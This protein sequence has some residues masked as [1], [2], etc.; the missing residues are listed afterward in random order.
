MILSIRRGTDP[1][2]DVRRCSITGAKHEHA[3]YIRTSLSSDMAKDTLTFELGGR[4]EITDFAAGIAAFS[5]LVNALTPRNSGIAWIVEDLQPGSAVVTFRG[6]SAD[7]AAVEH[8][9]DQYER[10][11]D[12]LERRE[13][14]PQINSRVI[15][16]I[17]AI[18]DL[19]ETTEYVRFQTSERDC[20]I[21][22]SGHTSLR[23]PPT[24]AI[25]AVTGRV[26]TL[27]NRGGLRF[28]LYDTLHDKAVACYLAPDQDEIM[29]EAWGSRATV[30][31]RVS[32][33]A[34]NGR[35]IAIRQ[36]IAV[37][38]LAET[39]RGSYQRARGTVAWQVGDR[40]P[41]EVIRDLRD[42]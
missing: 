35:P 38:S 37:E 24:V 13:D 28:N 33:D 12:T 39:E 32:R 27:S 1:N 42:A 11:G 8:I 26:Q 9:V 15:R 40:L 20:T 4:V 2:R 29:R 23:R 10:I 34:L 6:E 36:I 7:P 18:R 22:R 3:T 31:G 16:A 17:N 5:R 21:Y 41:E 30:T 14:P 25:G 19:T